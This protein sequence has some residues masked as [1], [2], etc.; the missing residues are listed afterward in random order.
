MNTVKEE[1]DFKRENTRRNHRVLD[2]YKVSGE[3][4]GNHDVFE[5]IHG[6]DNVVEVRVHNNQCN[7]GRQLV[8]VEKL[9]NGLTIG[10]GGA[11]KHTCIHRTRMLAMK[12]NCNNIP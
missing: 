5:N 10:R 3:D 6:E 1:G 9:E 12:Y 7:F 8:V 4:A 11:C 2:H